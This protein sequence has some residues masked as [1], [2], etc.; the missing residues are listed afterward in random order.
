[1]RE[2]ISYAEVTCDLCGKKEHINLSRVL[3]L[4]WDTIDLGDGKKDVCDSCYR[5]VREVIQRLPLLKAKKLDTDSFKT[6]VEYLEGMIAYEQA[7]EHRLARSGFS[8]AEQMDIQTE[9]LDK[10]EEDFRAGVE[11]LYKE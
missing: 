4:G 5:Y 10:A 7:C 1:M 6:N 2:N 11:D 8:D 9:V 3:P